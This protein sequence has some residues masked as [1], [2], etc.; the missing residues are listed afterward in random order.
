MTTLG[1]PEYLNSADVRG[2]EP[3]MV[4]GVVPLL[5]DYYHVSGLIDGLESW[6]GRIWG[7]TK[8]SKW[9]SFGRYGRDQQTLVFGAGEVGCRAGGLL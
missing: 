7:V 5:R 3:V 9:R 8:E 2:S 4:Y 6:R 1:L